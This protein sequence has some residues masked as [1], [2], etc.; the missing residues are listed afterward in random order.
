VRRFIG[1]GNYVQMLGGVG[2]VWS[3]D[4]LVIWRILVLVIAAV[5]MIG[6]IRRHRFTIA[7]VAAVVGL[8]VLAII[9]GFHPGASGYWNDPDFWN[10]LRNTLVFTACSTPL[11][12]GLGLVMALALQSRRRGHRLY[13]MAFFMPYV[14]PIS[15]V[16]LV[17][18][19]F[20]SPN[21]GLLAA[22]LKPFGVE[23]IAWLFDQNTAMIAIIIT[24]AWWTVGFNLVLFTAGL[25][26][27]DQALY[28]AASLDGAGRWNQFVHITLP[29]IRHV[30]LLVMI[31]QVIASFQI[32]GQVNIMTRGGPGNATDVLIRHIY[33]AGFRDF[34]LGYASAM[35]LVL[36]ALMLIVS[37]VQM[38]VI[39]Q[40]D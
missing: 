34:E 24:T 5:L 28:E 6:P 25:Q 7:R 18:A 3:P 22:I 26:D 11:I 19:Y 13:Q 12:A 15:V 27:V 21:Q 1:L 23:P 39:G 2:L 35:S 9:M 33:Q 30:L 31:M 38:R 40:G 37:V 36:F 17:W 10:A 16:T 4:H 14:L 32:F 20:L 8:V 29:S